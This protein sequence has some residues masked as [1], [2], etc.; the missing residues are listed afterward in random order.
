MYYKLFLS[1]ILTSLLMTPLGFAEN[2][3][4]KEALEQ[5][6]NQYLQE[7]ASYTSKFANQQN[8][9]A[10][11]ELNNIKPSVAFKVKH[12]QE[13]KKFNLTN[14]QPSQKFCDDLYANLV[15]LNNQLTEIIH[16]YSP[17]P[18]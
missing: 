7:I 12:A 3:C 11:A 16:K 8:Y 17:D 9:H 14:Y 5:A 13:I 4:T 18:D 10:V 1:S 15:D 6:N 2:N